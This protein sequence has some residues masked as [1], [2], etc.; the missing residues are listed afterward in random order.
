MGT[1]NFTDIAKFVAKSAY[2]Y[3]ICNT[4]IHRVYISLSVVALSMGFI[5]MKKNL[6]GAAR[7]RSQ[8]S[9]SMT[10]IS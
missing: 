1:H 2:T 7:S 4:Y 8:E 5:G 3:V 9:E 6:E 10:Q